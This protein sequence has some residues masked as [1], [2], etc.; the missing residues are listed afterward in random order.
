MPTVLTDAQR[1]LL[2]SYAIA[3][4]VP[5]AAIE[6]Y[7]TGVSDDTPLGNLVASAYALGVE[8]ARAG[9]TTVRRE[10]IKSFIHDLEKL[11]SHIAAIP[12]GAAKAKKHLKEL[13]SHYK[14]ELL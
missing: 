10:A 6:G 7:R 13:V 5:K 3:R 9:A 8:D 11:R 12:L 1:A 14:R 4:K 2:V